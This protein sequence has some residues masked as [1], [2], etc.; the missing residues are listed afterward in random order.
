VLLFILVHINLN[1][2][3]ITLYYPFLLIITSQRSTS[4]AKFTTENLSKKNAHTK[5]GALKNKH[6]IQG[7]NMIS[8]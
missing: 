5:V 7:G 6:K 4:I 1:K 2:L 3:K 8:I